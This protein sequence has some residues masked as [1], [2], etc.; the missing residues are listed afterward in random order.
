[1]TNVA[2]ETK[3]H[4]NTKR[5]KDGKKPNFI[6]Q[7]LTNWRFILF[8]GLNQ[9]GSLIN[10]IFIGYVNLGVGSV[11]SNG[12]ALIVA[13]LVE[14]AIGLN[15]ITIC[16]LRKTNLFRWGTRIRILHAWTHC[17]FYGISFYG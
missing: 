12:M 7:L 15:K 8:F 16:K 3:V 2:L 10:Q 11:V 13:Y 6:I 5:S 4:F 14:V 9:C 1:M 17:N